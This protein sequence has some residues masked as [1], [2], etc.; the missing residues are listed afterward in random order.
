MGKRKQAK[1]FLE[2]IG[3]TDNFCDIFV[4]CG[5]CKFRKECNYNLINYSNAKEFFT[6]WLEEHPKKK[7]KKY[8]PFDMIKSLYFLDSNEEVSEILK[9][10]KNILYDYGYEV[11][12]DSRSD[13]WYS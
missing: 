1:M 7:G 11:K 10:V 2:N 9:R 6:E 4:G 5:P 8:L 12:N 13:L 3:K